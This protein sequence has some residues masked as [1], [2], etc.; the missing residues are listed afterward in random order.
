MRTDHTGA[1]RNLLLAAGAFY[2][3]QWLHVLVRV[4]ALA[5]A[6]A[7]VGYDQVSRA[8]V[9]PFATSL[10][11]FVG[12]AAAGVAT[13][14]LVQSA[15]P[16]RW[17]MVPAALWLLPA[18]TELAPQSRSW[19]DGGALLIATALPSIVCVAAGRMAAWHRLDR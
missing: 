13:V 12:A 11:M 6:H 1:V 9:S 10:S 18:V 16:V 3:S 19:F 8:V 5:A 4:V 15:R 2:A 17:T 7:F 14:W